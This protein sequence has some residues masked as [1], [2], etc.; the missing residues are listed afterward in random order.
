[1][2]EIQTILEK[3]VTL[4]KSLS[5]IVKGKTNFIIKQDVKAL[6]ASLQ[7]EQSH[8]AAISALESKRIAAMEKSGHT[9]RSIEEIAGSFPEYSILIP[10]QKQLIDIIQDIKYANDLNNQLL[11]QSLQLIYTELDLLVPAK[12]EDSFNYTKTK[13]SSFQSN[14]IFNSKV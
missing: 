6:T 3:Q 12:R 9:A 7:K 4:H 11:T 14:S 5:V 8:I 13:N 1:M 2:Q 10:F